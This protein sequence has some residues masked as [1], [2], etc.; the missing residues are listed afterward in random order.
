MKSITARKHYGNDH[1]TNRN[2]TMYTTSPKKQ[3]SRG[4]RMHS[5]LSSD[6]Q[7]RNPNNGYTSPHTVH[8]V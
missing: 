7:Q 5:P 6:R 8:H 3:E 1:S 2:K 4:T